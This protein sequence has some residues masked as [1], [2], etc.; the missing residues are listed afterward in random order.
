MEKS[1]SRV[2]FD[3]AL[4]V[5]QVALLAVFALLFLLKAFTTLNW[6][7]EHDTPLMHYTAFMMDMHHAV[8]YRDIF[9]TDMPGTFAFHYAIGK[10]F[11]YGDAPFRY[12]D[13]ALLAILLAAI[14]GFMSRF[15]RWSALWAAILFGLVYLSQGQTMSLQR[16]YIGIIPISIALLCIPVKTGRPVGLWRFALIGLLF[17]MSALIKPHLAIALPI[18][19][20]A[21]LAFRWNVQRRSGRDF[22]M[23]AAV[24]AAS[25]MIPVGTAL[26]WL[27][28]HS[29]LG[30]FK[31]ILFKY[32]PLHNSLTGAHQSIYGLDRV[33]YLVKNTFTFGGFEALLLCALF[34][35]H[36][37][38]DKDDDAATA[39]SVS[40]LLLCTSIF[41]VY[42]AIAGMFWTYHY[43]PFAFFCV[44]SMGLCFSERPRLSSGNFTYRMKETFPVLIVVIAITVQLPLFHYASSLAV[45]LRLGSEAHAPKKGRVDEI[46]NWL[47]TRLRPG[48]LVQPLDWTGG[49]VH[50]ML[51]AEAKL[52]TR[53]MY[54]YCFYHNINDPYIKKLR[55]IFINELVLSKP[56]FIIQMENTQLPTGGNTNH[57]FPELQ[58]ILDDYYA[59]AKKGDGYRILE[60][61]Q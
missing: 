40:C 45:D 23:C 19:L 28:A 55:L 24:S 12:V 25:F 9:V 53:F 10:L 57:D 26:A 60:R 15:G 35:Y 41:A 54:N 5:F 29:A 4:L 20:G 14:Y 44:I 51:I 56:H 37:V 43:M 39:I 36:R 38:L 47:K 49:S 52:A 33:L 16:D 27:A 3:K 6:R 31:D 32:I 7:M 18:V 21:I 8:P 22:L 1:K 30:P 17:G 58:K 48:D 42:P 50:G 13:L 46:A 2:S 61:R 34:A 11:G 59:E